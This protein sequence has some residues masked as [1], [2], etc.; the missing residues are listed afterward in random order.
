MEEPILHALLA[1]YLPSMDPLHAPHVPQECMLLV[2]QH[3][4]VIPAGHTATPVLAPLS[5]R[6]VLQ[7]S[8]LELERL[9]A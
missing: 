5:A 1:V 7:E 8:T 6:H 3:R 2:P 4:P 9:L